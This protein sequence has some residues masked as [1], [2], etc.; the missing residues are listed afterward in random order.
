MTGR[1]ESRRSRGGSDANQVSGFVVQVA[2]ETELQ[3]V[4]QT[5]HW[6]N[7]AH[8]GDLR[9]SGVP[10]LERHVRGS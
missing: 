2:F 1:V 3:D 9:L 5:H 10:P 8:I 7:Q 4:A 6:P